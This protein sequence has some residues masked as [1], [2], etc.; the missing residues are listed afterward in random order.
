MKG[1]DNNKLVRL[2][3]IAGVGLLLSEKHIKESEASLWGLIVSKNVIFIHILKMFFTM[4]HLIIFL[5][6]WI[7]LYIFRISLC[8]TSPLK[9]LISFIIRDINCPFVSSIF[10]LFRIIRIAEVYSEPSRTFTME[11]FAKIV[12]GFQ[13]LIIFIKSSI[14]DIRMDFEYASQ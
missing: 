3:I 10:D 2:L 4:L 1:I 12:K 7:I 14:L 8:V 6:Y 13:L 9:S 5:E 11:L